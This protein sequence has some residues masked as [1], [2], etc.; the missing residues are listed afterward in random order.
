MHFDWLIYLLSSLANSFPQYFSDQQL[1]LFETSYPSLPN[2]FDTESLSSEYASTTTSV[3]HWNIGPYHPPSVSKQLAASDYEYLNNLAEIPSKLSRTYHGLVGIDVEIKCPRP[4]RRAALMNARY[5][6]DM[7][8]QQEILRAEED[9]QAPG[10]LPFEETQVDDQTES[11][12]TSSSYSDFA[13]PSLSGDH[14]HPESAGH[15]GPWDEGIPF[16]TSPETVGC[17]FSNASESSL[18]HS[19]FTSTSLSLSSSSSLSSLYLPDPMESEESL[20]NEVF[21]DQ[22]FDM[23]DYLVVEDEVDSEASNLETVS[24]KLGSSETNQKPLMSEASKKSNGVL[25]L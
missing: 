8:E 18:P 4:I 14:F 23:N 15:G 1:N 12:S 22:M 11:T 9:Q 16:T 13:Q 10:Q 25:G 20:L 2:P 21:P 7:V 17:S 5:L 19:S 6:M 24:M 3:N